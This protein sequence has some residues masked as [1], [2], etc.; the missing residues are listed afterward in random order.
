MKY[1]VIIKMYKFNMFI[2]AV[3]LIF[4]RLNLR[5]VSE[6]LVRKVQAANEENDM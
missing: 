2:T 1:Q 6:N 3:C 5:N 4:I